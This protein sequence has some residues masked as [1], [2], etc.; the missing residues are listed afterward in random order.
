MENDRKTEQAIKTLFDMH[1]NG[2]VGSQEDDESLSM[3]ERL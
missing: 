2:I 3:H 1:S